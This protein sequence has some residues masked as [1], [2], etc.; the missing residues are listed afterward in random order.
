MI[1]DVRVGRVCRDP[2][3]CVREM[4]PPKLVTVGGQVDVAGRISSSDR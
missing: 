3:I 2:L 4:R 1:E